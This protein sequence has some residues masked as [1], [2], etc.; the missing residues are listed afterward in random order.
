MPPFLLPVGP[1]MY[2]SHIIFV[3]APCTTLVKVVVI[4]VIV[5][6]CVSLLVS[7]WAQAGYFWFVPSSVSSTP[8]SWYMP[9]DETIP[10]VVSDQGVDLIAWPHPAKSPGVIHNRRLTTGNC[11]LFAGVGEMIIT[12]H[13]VPLAIFMPD[14]NDAILAR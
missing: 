14:H 6:L 7:G 10:A 3:G 12:G 5:P 2:V 9:L 4:V 8:D 1:A 13:I 11:P